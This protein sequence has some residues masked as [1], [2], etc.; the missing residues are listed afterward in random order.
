MSAAHIHE[1]SDK[2][3]REVDPMMLANALD[4]IACTAAKSR[5]Q[6]RRIRWIKLRAEYA[7][8]GRE[9]MEIDVDLPK[10]GGPNTAEKLKN[11]ADH[12]KRMNRELLAALQA[13]LAA[14]ADADTRAMALAVIDR[15]T[16]S[17]AA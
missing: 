10:D 17:D 5:T 4:H 6:T 11:K 12:L 9:Y 7:L 8:Q 2:A 16:G 3:A 15:V 13:V 14:S 1:R